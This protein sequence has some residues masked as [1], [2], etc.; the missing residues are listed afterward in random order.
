MN[1]ARHIAGEFDYI[2][3]GGGT[4]GCVLT[5]RLSEDGASVC[6]LEAGPRDIIPLIHIPAGYIKNVYSKTLTW[7]FESEPSPGSANRR[8]SLPQGRVPAAGSRTHCLSIKASSMPSA[9]E[10]ARRQ[11][12][13]CGIMS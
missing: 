5:N 2:V 4:A 8:F 1:G 12:G 11:S 3:I 10:T 7:N 6:L 9:L 13:Y